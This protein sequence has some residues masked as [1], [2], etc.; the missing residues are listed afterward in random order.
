MKLYLVRHGIAESN[1]IAKPDAERA[2]TPEGKSKMERIAKGL[3]HANVSIDLILTSPLVRARE[4][5]E[6]LA[7][8]LGGIELKMLPELA[9]GA[10]A[11]KV[12]QAIR[13]YAKVNA[14]ALVG[15]E[16]DL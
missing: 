6:I 9:S 3:A 2:L 10:T 1:S 15:H 14:L 7:R 13:R 12:A 16:P 8:G 11:T 4:T 5:A